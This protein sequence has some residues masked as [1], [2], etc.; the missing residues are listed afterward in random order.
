MTSFEEIYLHALLCTQFH[1]SKERA[2]VENIPPDPNEPEDAGWED[3][4]SPAS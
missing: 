3:D 4:I 1:L 2:A